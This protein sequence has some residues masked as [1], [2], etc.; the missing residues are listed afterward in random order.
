VFGRLVST[1]A[2]LAHDGFEL[3]VAVTHE[4]EVRVFRAGKAWRR[5]GWVVAGRSLVDVVD[6]VTIASPCD[7]LALLAQCITY[8]LR[9]CGVLETHGK[10]GRS[11]LY[12]LA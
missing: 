5:R 2:L 4:E 12:A 1:P 11:L 9:R 7:V 6:T 8:C 10:R 3:E